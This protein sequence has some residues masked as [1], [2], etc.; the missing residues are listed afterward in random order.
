MVLTKWLFSMLCRIYVDSFS[1]II[2]ESNDNIK[3]K[4]TIYYCLLVTVCRVSWTVRSSLFHDLGGRLTIIFRC[5]SISTNQ[6]FGQKYT[7]ITYKI[8]ISY[9]TL[10]LSYYAD[11]TRYKFDCMVE[12]AW[13]ALGSSLCLCV[14]EDNF[15]RASHSHSL[16]WFKTE[17][18]LDHIWLLL[19]LHEAIR[20]F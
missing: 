3:K 6:F 19:T 20:Q 13:L 15:L 12:Q 16:P 2:I 17:T 18:T 11:F 8:L 5:D 9:M 14:S 1:L 4:L 7:K 10:E